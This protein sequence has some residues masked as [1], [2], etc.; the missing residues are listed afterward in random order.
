MVGSSLSVLVDFFEAPDAKSRARFVRDGIRVLPMMVDY[1]ETRGHPR[2]AFGRVSKGKL[3]E[4][5]EM[6]MVFFEIESFTGPRY[7]IAV[8]WDG[9]RLVVDWESLTAYG[10]MDWSDFLEGKPES[11]QEM[12]AFLLE[13]RG[14][15]IV[16]GTP[17]GSM[18]F[19]VEHR[20]HPQPL[21][22]T[23]GPELAKTLSPMVEGRRV[24]VTLSL[25]W[26]PSGPGGAP[27]PVILR[28]IA[29]KWSP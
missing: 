26:Q 11:P 22:A 13:A 2:P 20:D 19:R 27:V 16:P 4:F 7:H 9:I 17:E 3:A 1:Y 15:P 24:P 29:P 6:P 18:V 5:D 28:L 8:V 21:I 25:A 10:T 23:A 12:R 14:I